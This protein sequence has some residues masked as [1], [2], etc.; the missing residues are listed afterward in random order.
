MSK[1]HVLP[2]VPP[3]EEP[4]W[5]TLLVCAAANV[6]DPG[7]APPGRGVTSF[8]FS[9]AE[10][11][12]PLV[13]GVETEYV[14]EA[15]RR[16][17]PARLHAPGRGRDV[18]RGDLAVDGQADAPERPL[19]DGDGERP[20]RRVAAEPAPA[21]V[22]RHASRA[23][24]ARRGITGSGH[25]SRPSLRPGE[26]E[27]PSG[28]RAVARASAR[29]TSS[30]PRPTPRYLLKEL[31]GWNSINDKFL[32]VTD[33][34]HYENLGLVELLRRG[35]RH[36]YCFDASGGRQLAPLG[37]AIAL[38][39]SELGVE[40]SFPNGELEQAEREED[41]VAKARARPGRSPTCA[42]TRR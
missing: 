23:D 8:T 5:P 28:A 7:A 24:A 3:W 42:P 13:G 22:V 16:D 29:G 14:R 33:G 9:A 21:R 11:G 39:R 30:V 27:R 15:L 19:P 26:F 4:G 1:T 36:I 34:G 2:Q 18:R 37:D 31:L 38:A 25:S 41:G 17:A 32:Y 10:M 6:S 40:I 12:G 20:A 35:C